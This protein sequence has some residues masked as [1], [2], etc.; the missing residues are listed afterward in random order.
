MK[1]LSPLEAVFFAALEKGSSEER[2]AYLDEACGHDPDL[3]RRVEKM[4][5]AQTQAK[6][7][8]ERPPGVLGTTVDAIGI[9]KPG[10]MVGPYKLLEQIGE[11]GFGEVFM[12]EQTQPVRR[13]VALKMLKPGMETRQVVARFE[14][15]RQALAI[16]DHPNIAKVYDGGATASGRPYFVMEL[17]KGVPITEFCDQNRLTPHERLDLFVPICRAVQ[18]AHQK[19]ILHRDLKPSNVLVTMHDG[20]PVVKVIDFGVAKALGQELTDKTLF[21]GFAQMIGTPLYMSPEQAGLSGLDIDTRSDIYS[22]GVLLYELL[23]GTTPF[24]KEQLR[25]AGYDEMRRILREEEPPTPSTR[26]S[27]SKESLPSI[28][29]RRQTE[30]TRLTRLVRGDLD[31]IVMRALE[32]DR[33]RRYDSASALAADVEHFLK[34][35]PVTAGPPGAWYRF[36]K[37]VRRNRGPALAGS[38]LLLALVGGVIGTSLGLLRARQAIEAERTAKDTAQH[39]LTQI[40]KSFEL[41]G[42]VFKD[43]DPQSTEDGGRPLRVVLSEHLDQATA[44]LEGDLIGDPLAVARLQAVLGQSQLGLGNARKAIP[45][46]VKAR[47]TFTEQETADHPDTLDAMN[48]LARGYYDLGKLDLAMPL[49]KETLERRRAA[50]GPD[51]ADTLQSL[52]DYAICFRQDDQLDLAVPLLKEALERR[53]ATLGPDHLDTLESMN[54]LALA[55]QDANKLDLALPLF[56]A[57]LQGR[58]RK[59]PADHADVLQS[60]NN[61]ARAYRAAG[62]LGPAEALFEATLKGIKDKVGPDHP[63]TLKTMSN[64]ALTYHDNGKVNLAVPLYEEALKRMKGFPGDHP[65]VL[66]GMI[67]LAGGYR[68]TGKLELALPL[69]EEALKIFKTKLGAEHRNTLKVMHDL[70]KAYLQAGQFANAETVLSEYVAV[71]EKKPDARMA[72]DTKSLLGAALMGQKRFDKAEPL[73]MAG[74]QETYDH[75]VKAPSVPKTLLIEA[76]ERLVQFYEATGNPDEAKK[77]HKKLTE[78]KAAPKSATK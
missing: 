1:D 6:S 59:L 48:L 4:L 16:M 33:V 23:T 2:A 41:L 45:L 66:W 22:L 47:A 63:Y 60:M 65:D 37:F 62:K 74:Y 14:A 77:W 34:D 17:I 5:A 73:L 31:W 55:Y 70:G 29:A 68:D 75:E 3:R 24:S 32:K 40:E 12:A 25:R 64:L 61:L 28:A 19:G 44:Q 27:G 21:T 58:K 78:V 52:N 54:C 36:R 71:L 46:L 8:L 56:E 51:H 49:F 30:P 39:R 53:K 57:T 9:E 38:L 15:E 76:L 13:R 43:L 20:K 72:P 50:L 42:S 35:E 26:L 11:G 18:H 7:F 67:N 10:A 69:Y